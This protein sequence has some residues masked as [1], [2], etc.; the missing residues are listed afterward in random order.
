MAIIDT[1]K[2]FVNQS[3]ITTADVN[4][5]FTDLKNGT[6]GTTGKIDTQNVRSGAIDR[7]HLADTFTVSGAA[8]ASAA[9]EGDNWASNSGS[10]ADSI[11]TGEPNAVTT[12]EEL[13]SLSGVTIKQGEVIRYSCDAMI[14]RANNNPGGSVANHTLRVE[15][16]V[17]LSVWFKFSPTNGAAD[18]WVSTKNFGF[19]STNGPY[20]YNLPG[21]AY[22]GSYFTT[23]GSGGNNCL[24]RQI[25]S[26]A[27]IFPAA[28]AA[29]IE[30]VVLKCHLQNSN[31]VIYISNN[32]VSAI[33]LK[34]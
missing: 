9:G 25:I 15:Q 30:K 11:D 27:Y 19:T 14:R 24:L 20:S 29:T 26:G 28:Q 17:Y 12:V 16:Q 13:T 7:E 4:T 34:N 22:A 2:H 32:Q 5:A 31:N 6:D 8:K 18:Y 10:A 1:P 21:V 33:V 3:T 23:V